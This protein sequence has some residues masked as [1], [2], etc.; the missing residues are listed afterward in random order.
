LTTEKLGHDKGMYNKC[1]VTTQTCAGQWTN[2]DLTKTQLSVGYRV[3]GSAKLPGIVYLEGGSKIKD[4]EKCLRNPW[5]ISSRANAFFALHR[6][7]VV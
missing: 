4:C 7:A 6:D 1:W 3:T 2:Y 5:E